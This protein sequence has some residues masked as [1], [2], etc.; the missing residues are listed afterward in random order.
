VP[1]TYERIKDTLACL[2]SDLT[3]LTNYNAKINGQFS[4]SHRWQFLYNFS[5]KT[6]NA[7]GAAPTRPPETVYRQY[8][9]SNPLDAGYVVKHTWIVSDKLVLENTAQYQAGGFTLDFQDPDTQYDLQPLFFDDSNTWGRSIDQYITERP[10]TE[11]KTDGNYLKSNWIGG[12][13]QLKFGFRYRNTPIKSF[14]HFGGNA[15]AQFDRDDDDEPYV[16]ELAQ[17]YRDENIS[18]GLYTLSAYLQDSYSK[19]RLRLNLGIRWDYQDDE[20]KPSHA[21]ANPIIPDLL[22]AI[23]FP[24]H[25]TGLV[26]NDFAP[27]LSATYDLFGNGKTV[28][29]GTYAMYFTQG[30]LFSDNDNPA[31]TVELQADWNDANGDTIIQRNELDLSTLDVEDG[32]FEIG[33]GSF[34]FD[35]TTDPNLKND[36]TRE[37]IGTISHELMP[38]FGLD[39]SY[40]YRNYD[41]GNFT[42]RIGET[43]EMWIQREWILTPQEQANLPAGLP[44][45]GWFYWEIA[46]GVTRPANITHR[47]QSDEYSTYH[48]FEVVARKRYSDRWFMQGSLTLNNTRDFNSTSTCLDCTNIR[49]VNLLDGYNTDNR[50]VAKLNGGYT[51]P[52]GFNLSANV[53]IQDGGARGIFYRAPNRINN[54]RFGGFSPT[55][56]NRQTLGAFDF[57][58]EPIGT[59]HLP[60]L[61]MM[62][63]QMDKT[64]RIGRNRLA[65]TATV[66]NVFNVAT[67]RG[68]SSGRLDQATQFTR[69]SSIVAPRVFR[70]M[71]KWSF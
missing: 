67:I 47:S 31:G 36:R 58:V 45:T 54:Q 51:L 3:V 60:T 66:F 61:T 52:K 69:V 14:N 19:G 48:G 38:N 34:T 50:F 17:L 1:N 25:D 42:R 15:V 23:D 59:T 2:K 62:D 53:N 4:S 10:T 24:G 40:I 13:H 49:P 27:R 44:T 68:Y 16:P 21:D 46:P 29:K 6:R 33:T 70:A 71:L 12:E 65:L 20:A 57:R 63:A 56:G 43:P 5:D 64:F 41:R 18:I 39:F 55:T 32:N 8:N 7:R 37:I 22:P 11:L 30:G 35:N 9:S 28:L 26:Y